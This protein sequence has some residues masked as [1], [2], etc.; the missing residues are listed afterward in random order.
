M[1][2]KTHL[3]A[4]VAISPGRGA[5]SSSPRC[6]RGRSILGWRVRP[7][8][9][10]WRRSRASPAW[11]WKSMASRSGA[12]LMAT[13]RSPARR[14]ARAAALRGRTEATR[15]PSAWLG[16]QLVM[17]G[18]QLVLERVGGRVEL[19]EALDEVLQPRGDRE[20][21]HDP[22]RAPR[23]AG[24]DLEVVGE[25]GGDDGGDLAE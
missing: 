24:Q 3:F 20:E 15:T 14:P 22:G 9:S 21:G 1:K 12:P 5:S 8:R 11:K 10:I 19:L 25:H 7:S 18:G 4:H 13:M 16:A 23:Q 6:P 2:Q 17:L